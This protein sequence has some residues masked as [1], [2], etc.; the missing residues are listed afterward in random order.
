MKKNSVKKNPKPLFDTIETID[1]DIYPCVSD[2]LKTLQITDIQQQYELT[3][4]FLRSY[5]GSPDTFNAYRREV[6][7]FLQWCWLILHKTLRDVD[8]NDIRQ[9]LEFIQKPPLQWITTKNVPRF[10]LKNGIRQQNA[11]W[12]PFVVRISKALHREG[13]KPDR[14]EYQLT[15]KSI[16]ALFAVL[17]TYFTFLQQEGFLEINPVQLIR[18]KNR[19]LQRQ[20]SLKVTRKLSHIQWHFV[21]EAIEQEANKDH[22]YERALFMI[23]AFYLLGL[24]ISEL[25]DTPGRIPKMGDFAPDKHDRWWFTTVGKGNKV[26]DVAVPNA[27]L[28]A[29]KR[30]RLSRSLSPLPS[31]GEQTPLL[32]KERGRGGLGTRQIRNLVQSCFDRAINSLRQAGKHDEAQDLAVATVH[33]LRHTAIS[34]DIEHRPREHVRDDAGHENATV[35]DRYI[36]TDRIARHESA[37]NKPLKPLME[38][39]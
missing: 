12:R 35:T 17:S 6:E 2:Y 8:R 32:H 1:D 4:E 28:A 7:R 36:D 20:Q 22:A 29:L 34:A 23:S 14:D 24:R 10:V 11:E 33:W 9:Y 37:K 15:H 18:Q 30:Y 13:I 5:A 3:Q 38:E 16:Q 19:F 31:R 21:I 25:A 27:M 26:R 39:Q